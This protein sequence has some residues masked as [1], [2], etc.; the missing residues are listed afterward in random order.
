MKFPHGGKNI[1]S[2]SSPWSPLPTNNMQRRENGDRTTGDRVVVARERPEPPTNQYRSHSC[3]VFL[4]HT[5][6][7]LWFGQLVFLKF[8]KKGGLTDSTSYHK[9]RTSLLLSSFP[10][11]Q[12]NP[13]HLIARN[14][15]NPNYGNKCNLF[16]PF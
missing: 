16:S 3:S 4:L 2:L 7:N 8:Q 1:S 9:E 14:I 11:P 5:N 6:P 12:N 10:Q 13:L 15:N